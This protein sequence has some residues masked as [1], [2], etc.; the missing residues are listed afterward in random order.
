MATDIGQEQ[1]LQRKAKAFD[2]SSKRQPFDGGDVLHN[3]VAWLRICLHE[4]EPH[5][6]WPPTRL[7]SDYTHK[8]AY[9]HAESGLFHD[10]ASRARNGMFV[11]FELAARQHPEL[12][13]AALNDSDPRPRTPA[14][15]YSTYRVY[16]S[17]HET[18]RLLCPTAKHAASKSA[19]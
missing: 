16:G 11:R 13:L 4:P 15:R 17:A 8:L 2:C 18:S 9:L 19:N 7:V 1:L 5:D 14:H 12:V 3:L 10:L 6:F